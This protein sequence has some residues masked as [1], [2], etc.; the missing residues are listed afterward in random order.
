MQH[1]QPLKC[2]HTNGKATKLKQNG[3]QKMK[4]KSKGRP[5]KYFQK[6]KETEKFQHDLAKI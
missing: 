2:L 1:E 3:T 6:K 5:H 4:R